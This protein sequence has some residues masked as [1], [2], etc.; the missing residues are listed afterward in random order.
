V[1]LEAIAALES[2]RLSACKTKRLAAK[3][4]KAMQ[5]KIQEFVATHLHQRRSPPSSWTLSSALPIKKLQYYVSAVA[6]MF[7]GKIT[8]KESISPFA[9]GE[10]FNTTV[11]G[12]NPTYGERY[13]IKR[14]LYRFE[15]YRNLFPAYSHTA[16]TKRGTLFLR[17]SHL[18]KVSSQA[19][20]TISLFGQSLQVYSCMLAMSSSTNKS[21]PSMTL[22]STIFSEARP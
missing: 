3:Y 22:Q 7:I 12:L 14:T 17:T 21:Q 1:L 15:V 8:T 10:I 19:A 6:R 2:S 13:R 11:R 18:V 9:S 4:Q 20:F 5:E 16:Q